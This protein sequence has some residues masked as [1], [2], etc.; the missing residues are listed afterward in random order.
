MRE[1]ESGALAAEKVEEGP[2]PPAKARLRIVFV[3]MT[4][5]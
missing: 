4:R 3:R 5:P 2:V 1:A